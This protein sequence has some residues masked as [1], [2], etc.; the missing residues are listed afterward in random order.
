VEGDLIE[1]YVAALQEHLRWRPDVVDVV[2]EVADHLREHVDRLVAS[3][4]AVDDAQRRTLEC[5]GDL[6]LVARSFAQTPSGELAVPTRSTRLAG[7]AGMAAGV[8]WAAA[9]VVGAG[10]G[11]TDLLTTWTLPRYELWVGVLVVAL[12]LTTVTIAGVLRRAGRLAGPAGVTSLG[13]GVLL[14][15]GMVP[16]GWGVTLVMTLLGVAVRCGGSAPRGCSAR[17]PCCCSTRSTRWDGSTSTATTPSRGSCRSSPARCARRWC[18]LSSVP[19]WAGSTPST[20]IG[21]R[22]PPPPPLREPH[23]S[24]D[25]VGVHLP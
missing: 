23:P 10:G 19:G 17:P 1:A 24:R 2:D 20:S 12:A 14:T 16:I 21:Y 5:F 11:H 22:E 13:V 3:G 25:D 6:G 8:A 18:S 9:A 15:V 4:A 7:A